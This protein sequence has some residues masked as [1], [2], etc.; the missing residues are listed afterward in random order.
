MSNTS[1][2]KPER[3]P[4]GKWGGAHVRLEVHNDGAEIEYDCAHGTLAGPLRLDGEGRFHAKGT[5]VRERGHIRLGETPPGRPARFQGRVSA[6]TMTLTV[7]LE[8]STEDLGT[9]TLT[10]GSDGRLWKCR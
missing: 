7:T 3:V 6:R 10:Q 5:H 9:F 8:D 1:H 4:P 2:E